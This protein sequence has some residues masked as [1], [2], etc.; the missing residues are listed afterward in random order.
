MKGKKGNGVRKILMAAIIP[1]FPEMC[2]NVDHSTEGYL[3]LNIQK[4][5]EGVA[6]KACLVVQQ[7]L[8]LNLC[9]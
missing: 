4:L 5:L 2:V 9:Y 6:A 1:G 3:K 7:Y 8:W